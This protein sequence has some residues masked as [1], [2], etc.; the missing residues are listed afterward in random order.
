MLHDSIVVLKIH[1]ISNYL[2]QFKH[3]S[4]HTAFD[5]ES[6]FTTV[7]VKEGSSD[8]VHVDWNDQGI[9]WVLPIGDWEGGNMVI[10]RLRMELPVRSG[11]LLGFWANLLAHYSKPVK[12]GKRVVI[13][14]FTCR[15]VF[16]NAVLYAR[17]N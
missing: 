14:M 12:S 1:R 9:T 16:S 4:C 11:E 6:A 13:T 10:P 8:E 15:N 2:S 17:L 5:F 3:I 7:A